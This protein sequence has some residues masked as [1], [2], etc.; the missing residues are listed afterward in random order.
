M[1]NMSL[2][3]GSP[4]L[5]SRSYM[6]LGCHLSLAAVCISPA[7][8]G[9]F[10][11]FLKPISEETGWE[12]GEI[13][14]AVSVVSLLSA[15]AT[16]LGGYLVDR[17]GAKKVTLIAVIGVPLLSG[18]MALSPPN[19]FAFIFVA[20]LLGLVAGLSS[21]VGYV[22]ILPKWFD[23]RL[24]FALAITMSGIGVGQMLNSIIANQLINALGWRAGWIGLC[25]WLFIVVCIGRLL[26]PWGALQQQPEEKSNDNDKP[27]DTSAE[28]FNF[29]KQPL[30][31]SLTV[32]FFLVLVVTAGTQLNIAAAISDR[33]LPTT[34]G[35]LAVATMGASSMIA[36]LLGGFLLDIMPARWLSAIIFFVQ[37]LGCILLA[38]SSSITA[39]IF[40]AFLISFAFGVESDILPY[41]VRRQFGTTNFGRKY[42]SMFGVVQLGVVVGPFAVAT[43]FDKLGSYYDAFLFLA[44]CSFVAAVLVAVALRS[45][46]VPEN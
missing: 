4:G 1:N 22:S 14:I 9:V 34:I 27:T 39:I 26:I 43:S 10:G 45:T 23:H 8:F 25:V 30:F 15:I 3:R 46:L 40:S 37:A 13:A 32:A 16:P 35:A 28:G 20:S 19:F 44:G 11:L 41:V 29:L 38:I 18:L 17:W 36:R 33:G 6:L 24:G 2:T 5:L 7:F 21:P 12:R 31:W 42:G